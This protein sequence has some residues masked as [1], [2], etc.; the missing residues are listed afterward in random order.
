ETARRTGIRA[1]TV[2]IDFGTSQCESA[3]DF[4]KMLAQVAAAFHQVKFTVIAAGRAMAPEATRPLAVAPRDAN[5]ET[6]IAVRRAR[7]LVEDAEHD[8]A[9]AYDGID[10]AG[11]AP[12]AIFPFH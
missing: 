4:F 8:D 3:A 6:I 9:V 2:A 5:E 12:D 10:T 7:R 11:L 1:I